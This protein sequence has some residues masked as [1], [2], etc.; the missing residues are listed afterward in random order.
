MFVY[1]LFTA[2]Y[3]DFIFNKGY[4]QVLG[5][6]NIETT[7]LLEKQIPENERLVISISNYPKQRIPLL[8][9]CRAN[10]SFHNQPDLYTIQ[11]QNCIADLNS[12]D[13]KRVNQQIIVEYNHKNNSFMN[14]VFQEKGNIPFIMVYSEQKSDFV[15]TFAFKQKQS[16]YVECQYGSICFKGQCLCQ[17]GFFGDD[18]SIN[19]IQLQENDNF[20]QDVIYYINATK[21]EEVSMN[22]TEKSNFIIGCLAFNPYVYRGEFIFNSFLELSYQKQMDCL[23]ETQKVN[24]EFS[25]NLQPFYV[26]IAQQDII[27]LESQSNES[28]KNT[29]LYI[30]TSIGISLLVV[31]VYCWFHFK[32][33][34]RR[35]NN[36]I[37]TQIPTSEQM[38]SINTINKYLPIQIYDEVIKKFPGLAD[39]QICQI[40]LETYKKEDQV[41]ITYCTHFYHVECIDLWINKND[42]CPTCRS[43]LNI[44]TLNKFIYNNLEDGNHT[45]ST[46]SKQIIFEQSHKNIRL[47]G[48]NR[49][50]SSPNIPQ[51]IS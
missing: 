8:L 26:F 4:Q 35:M 48:Y 13:F 31:I 38:A 17:R 23:E 1:L 30:V 16:C 21:L 11:K 37:T 25:I 46:C 27:Y 51:K 22:F 10:H 9:F 19:I 39:D 43:S 42:K 20:E 32:K 6:I 2:C 47:H 40:C 33:S 36:L 24:K 49:T 50:S 14:I 44:Q 5:Q 28:N 29:I 3:A 7:S 34:N 12:Y 18:C 45:I 15:I 41:R